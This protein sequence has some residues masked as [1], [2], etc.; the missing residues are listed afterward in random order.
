MTASEKIEQHLSAHPQNILTVSQGKLRLAKTEEPKY[1]F[2]IRDIQDKFGSVPIFLES[3]PAQGFTS[4]TIIDLKR[5]YKSGK[6]QSLYK[7][8]TLTLN[9]QEKTQELAPMPAPLPAPTPSG[10]GAPTLS[11]MPTVPITQAAACSQ[12]GLGAP[13]MGA[14]YGLGYTPVATTDWISSKVI[15]E[16]YRD[17][18]R[19]NEQLREDNKDLR[20]QVRVLSEEKASL[21]LQLDTAEKKHELHLKEELLAK[22]GFWESPAFERVSESL[23]AIAPM[24]MERMMSTP[25]APALAAPEGTP[26]QQN[27]PLSTTG[28]SIVKQEFIRIISSSQ[29]TDEQVGELYDLLIGKKEE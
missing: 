21:R 2:S 24:I 26:A 28:L 19:D 18:Q 17:L 6:S 25:P 9:F 13:Q 27:N 22:K 20:S 23:G 14:P 3:L 15:E 5:I 10:S 7:M 4:G 11:A 8:D 16:R 1:A 29:V 12:N